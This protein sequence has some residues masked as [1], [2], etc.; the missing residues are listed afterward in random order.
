MASTAWLD[1]T[2]RPSSQRTTTSSVAVAVDGDRTRAL[3]QLDAA[4]EEVVLEHRRHLRVLGRQH[5]LARR[6]RGSPSTPN[7]EN[8]C[9]N[10]TPV[11]PDPTTVML[12]GNSLR[13]VAVA[14]G[15]D[16]VA[17][18]V[19]PVGDARP[20]AGRD[21][22][23]V[24]ADHLE[25]VDGR[26]SRRCAGRGEPRRAGD[27]AHAL[28]LQQLRGA[29]LQVR[30]DALDP[31]RQRVGVDLGVV[32]S[33]PIPRNGAGRSSPRR[34]RSSSST[35]CSRGGGRRRRSGRA[36]PSSPRRRTG[37]RTWRRCCRRGR[38]R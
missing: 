31:R 30:L 21:E 24:G 34:W 10:S 20:R 8:M 1:R 3:Q 25:P 35:G 29:G 7:E 38:R 11:T 28:A 12:V 22:R 19:A 18:G 32:S 26:R 36:R 23:G 2:T 37:R 16:A 33:R 27:H 15:E 9:T 6:R 5:L 13:R 4:L 17:V 14:G